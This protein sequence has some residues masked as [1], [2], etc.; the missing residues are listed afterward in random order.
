MPHLT[1]DQKDAILQIEK[2]TEIK[3][4]DLDNKRN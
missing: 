4:G 2:S 1:T 3:D